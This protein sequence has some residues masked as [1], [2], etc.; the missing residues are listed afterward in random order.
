MHAF[1][2]RIDREQLTGARS[3][4]DSAIVTWSQYCPAWAAQ[5]PNKPFDEL[6]F[7]GGFV[8]DGR[9]MT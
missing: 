9:R 1:D 5:T 6:K 4:Q 7:S 3:G 8:H 2:H